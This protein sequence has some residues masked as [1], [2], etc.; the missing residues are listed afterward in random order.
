[1]KKIL[2]LL[3]AVF[4]LSG[5]QSLP[6]LN[7]AIQDVEP[8]KNKIDGELKS[9]SVSLAS[10][11]EK[12]GD[13]EAGMEAVPMLWKSA[14]D[15]ALA[16]NV[17][18]KDDSTR[19]LSLSVKVLAINSPSFGAEMKT[20]SIARYQLTDRTN[21]KVVYSKEI[22]AE[23]VVPFSY[24]FAGIV[25]ARESINRSVQNNI[26]EFLQELDHIDINKPYFGM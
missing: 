24:A 13:I 8:S 9:V 6:P 3:A 25:R 26:S 19:K 1:M 2:V 11:E 17:I 10:P 12:K 15:D 23:G 20:V 21:G 5:C 22:T 16:R 18:F 14:L 7:F 4:V